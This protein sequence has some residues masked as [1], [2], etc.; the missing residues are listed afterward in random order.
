M[1]T[2]IKER[3]KNFVDLSTDLLAGMRDMLQ[4]NLAVC[5]QCCTISQLYLLKFLQCIWQF[6]WMV[7]FDVVL[8]Q[9]YQALFRDGE[10]FLHVVSLLNSDLD[11]ANGEKLVL[12]VLQTLTYLLAS[13][14]T[15]K[16]LS[17]LLFNFSPFFFPCIVI[18]GGITVFSPICFD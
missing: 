5:V 13:N 16:V 6:N 4:A 2:Q 3:E 10:C 9:Y 11:E 12:N 17:S 1:F 18:L 7:L 14:D 15:S 8:F